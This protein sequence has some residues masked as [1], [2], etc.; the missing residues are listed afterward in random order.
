MTEQDNTPDVNRWWHPAHEVHPTHHAIFDVTTSHHI[1]DVP[2]NHR[3]ANLGLPD[4]F[5]GDSAPPHDIITVILAGRRAADDDPM[6]DNISYDEATGASIWTPPC[7]SSPVWTHPSAA[8]L[9]RRDMIRLL[10]DW[11]EETF[12]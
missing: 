2:F 5:F 1:V 7:G 11:I 9:P 12:E 4:W 10:H 3:D 6:F 8:N